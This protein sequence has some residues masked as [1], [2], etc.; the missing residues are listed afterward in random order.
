LRRTFEISVR[1]EPKVARQDPTKGEEGKVRLSG[2]APDWN[3]GQK[4]G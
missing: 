3:S 1:I 2:A 4:L